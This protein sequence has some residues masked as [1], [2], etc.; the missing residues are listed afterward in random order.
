MNWGRPTI[1][2]FLL[3][4]LLVGSGC[5]IMPTSG[6]SIYDVKSGEPKEPDSLPYALVRLNPESIGVI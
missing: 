2:T 3:G 1:G 5:A 4:A 6:P